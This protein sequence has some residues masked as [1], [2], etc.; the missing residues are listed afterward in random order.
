MCY[1]IHHSALCLLAV[2]ASLSGC[3]TT[4]PHSD[5]V[6]GNAVRE[7]LAAQTIDP[8]AARNRDPVYGLDSHA[9]IAAQR[10]YARSFATP[11]PAAVA[12][13]SDIAR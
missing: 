3:V 6:F 11:E 10:N 13:T 5:R 9:A 4:T 8:N 7:G 12:N 1:R 2:S